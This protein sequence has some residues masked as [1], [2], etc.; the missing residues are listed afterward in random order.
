[1]YKTGD[2][3]RHRADGTIEFLGRNDQLV[4]IRG[5][6]VEMG[7]IESALKAQ[8]EIKQAVVVARE[9]SPGDKRLVAYIVAS[10]PVLPAS[11]ELRRR[12]KQT[13]PEYSVPSSY[14]FLDRLPVSPAGKI[15]IKALPQP[16]IASSLANDT[17]VAPRNRVEECA[18]N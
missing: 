9:D 18:G 2:T 3:V 7:E 16:E 4:K 13:L 6:R 15:D 8:P 5:F 1:M 11:S 12:L 14:V 10:G 17:Y